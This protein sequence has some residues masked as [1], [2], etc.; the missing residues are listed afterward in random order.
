M[1]IGP[2]QEY[3]LSQSVE[4]PHNRFS[5]MVRRATAPPNSVK[6]VD[7]DLEPDT[8]ETDADETEL[9]ELR[10]EPGNED[11][12]MMQ[13]LEQRIHEMDDGQVDNLLHQLHSVANDEKSRKSVLISF[14]RQ[15]TTSHSRSHD[16]STL[17]SKNA[18]Q[19][20][21]R[22][23]SQGILPHHGAAAAATQHRPSPLSRGSVNMGTERKRFGTTGALPRPSKSTL[24][25]MRRRQFYE[26]KQADLGDN[27][28]QYSECKGDEDELTMDDDDAKIDDHSDCKNNNKYDQNVSHHT[29][30]KDDEFFEAPAILPTRPSLLFDTLVPAPDTR[31]PVNEER[32]PAASPRSP[33]QP[34]LPRIGGPTRAQGRSKVMEPLSEGWP[35]A[36]SNSLDELDLRSAKAEPTTAELALPCVDGLDFSACDDVE[37]KDE[38]NY[39]SPSSTTEHKVD[40]LIAWTRDLG[41]N[42]DDESLFDDQ[43]GASDDDDELTLELEM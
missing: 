29:E 43:A 4:N 40:D 9:L 31:E 12:S 36:I 11:A 42:S 17:S 23:G 13:L 41:M 33:D 24:I 34:N 14:F 32:S 21:V 38:D 1:Y 8:P 20:R 3:Q 16:D 25:A 37:F 35:Q 18:K 10:D 22:F 5:R 30:S 19:H 15:N 7:V 6:T 2:W 39:G 26:S 28:D 27:K